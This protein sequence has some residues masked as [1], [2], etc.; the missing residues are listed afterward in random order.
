MTREMMAVFLT[1]ALDLPAGSADRFVDDNSSKFEAEIQAL[2][3]S[4]ITVGC[5]DTQYCPNDPV[6]REQMAT[7][8][9]RS[10]G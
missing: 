6:T 3:K 7:F 5:S 10:F 1:R 8:L 4:G 2:A 9:M